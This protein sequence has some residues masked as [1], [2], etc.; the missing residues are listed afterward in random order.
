MHIRKS[1]I[2][3]TIQERDA[4]LAA[5]LALKQ[6]PAPESNPANPPEFSFYDQFIAIHTAAVS[7]TA[8]INNGHSHNLGHGNAGFLPWHRE[9]LLRLQ[10]GVTSVDSSVVLPY[11]DWT[12]HRAT[13]D[14]LFTDE[15]MGQRS[16][17]TP[18][19]PQEVTSG[20]FTAS[21]PAN[22]PTWWPANLQ[23]WR[24]PP[25]LRLPW[26]N[27][28]GKL[29]RQ[30][31]PESDLP[32]EETIE[33]LLGMSTY[34]RFWAGLERGVGISSI[35][36]IEFGPT[37]NWMHGWVGGHMSEPLISPFDP[38]FS[39]N[40]AY[41][42]YL[43]DRWQRDGHGGASF[44][45]S[46]QDW[47]GEGM[48]GE[49]P[50]GHLLDDALYPWV[51]NQAP[52]YIADFEQ[53]HH[54]L[55]NV[56][57]ETARHPRDLLQTDDLR[58]DPQFNYQYQDPLPRFGKVKRI[59]DNIISDWMTD[60]GRPPNLVHVHRD[61]QFGWADRDQLCNCVARGLPLIAPSLI[62]SNRAEETMLVQILRGRVNQFPRMPH[63]GPY[64]AD[65]DIDFVASWIDH[66]CLDAVEPPE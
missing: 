3:L 23:G 2:D 36:Q 26:Q 17:V 13:L 16:A 4:F 38:V 20:Y 9:F 48:P 11:W 45:P 15:F 51:G 64:L 44:Y 55:P 19:E 14:Y 5:L 28:N 42:D 57:G 63:N 30:V 27:W 56:S 29:H 43:W 6:L 50:R 33:I 10:K 21:R 39:L 22:P 61:T 12:A 49:I 62:G 47:N 52:N 24:V 60:R 65:A 31:G 37:H 54:F 34:R 58:L 7:V 18:D 41:V 35:P 25:Q 40:H 59:L 53:T 46:T 66:G 1:F 32:T 8:V